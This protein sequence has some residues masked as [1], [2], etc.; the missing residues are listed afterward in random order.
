MHGKFSCDKFDYI[1]RNIHLWRP[2]DKEVETISE[3][4][5]AVQD[6]EFGEDKEVD[7]EVE[8]V[9]KGDDDWEGEG[10]DANDESDADADFDCTID[11]DT[12]I[13]GNN[14]GVIEIWYIKAKPSLDHVNKFSIEEC[15][16]PGFNLSL[17]EVMK[18]L[19]GQS[20]MT[21]RVNHIWLYRWRRSQL[22]KDLNSM[23]QQLVFHS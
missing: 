13:E 4:V 21:V 2:K 3:E 8:T 14:E 22:R 6:D 10:I 23:I 17:N 15:D 11:V 7:C 16:Y 1:W 12:D 20:Y 5:S 19:K 9:E 18:L